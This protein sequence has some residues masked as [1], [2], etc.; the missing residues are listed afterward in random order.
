MEQEQKKKSVKIVIVVLAILLGICLAALVGTLVYNYVHKDTPVTAT[1]PD[2]VITPEQDTTHPTEDE[3]APTTSAADTAKKKQHATTIA[4][5]NKQPN[6]NHPFRVTNMFPGDSELQYYRVRVSYHN[7]VT[8]HFKA[9]IRPG[10]DV[11]AQ[12]LKVKVVLQTTGETLYDGLMRDMPASL[13][14]RLS[15][16]E[17]TTDELSY[18]ITA[19]LETS[20]GNAYQNTDLIADFKWWVTEPEN[21]TPPKTGD[22]RNIFLFA[23]VAFVTGAVL[24]ILVTRRRKK[25]DAA[26]G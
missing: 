2:N 22:T 23:G 5:Y 21:L 18:A 20:V 16:K 24:I 19:Y 6:D 13:T 9:D 26:N 7:N 25:E 15:A 17:E 10:S 4:L 8:V 3:T 12:V 14:H 11:L 1:V